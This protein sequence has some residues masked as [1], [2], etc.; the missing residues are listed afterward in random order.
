MLAPTRRGAHRSV[1]PLRRT[2]SP[3][4]LPGYG[5]PTAPLA[6]GRTRAVLECGPMSSTSTS[7][8]RRARRCTRRSRRGRRSWRRCTPTSTARGRWS[9]GPRFAAWS[10]VSIGVAVSQAAA[11]FLRRAL[12]RA[13]L[14]IVP[15]GVD[16]R[17][18]ADAEP[19]A[20]LPAGRRI[21]WAHRLDPQKGFFVAV[22]AFAKVLAEVPD[23]VLLV[24]GDGRTAMPCASSP[25][26]AR[27]RSPVGRRR[28]RPTARR[29]T[30]HATCS[31]R[32]PSARRASA[33][34]WSR[35]W[36]PA[37]PSPATSPVPRGRRRRRR[38]PPRAAAGPGGAGGRP[39]PGPAGA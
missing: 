34:P 6:Y 28:E 33:S 30:P 9:C 8:S 2:S 36:R 11:T 18:F 22:A 25:G 37:S 12:P 29:S 7:R 35:R 20:D 21:A 23:A 32:P 39:G 24:A 38:G 19:R 15:N 16:V 26:R 10:R 13:E 14:E 1:G 27:A 4:V 31:S 5:R 17:A 3:S